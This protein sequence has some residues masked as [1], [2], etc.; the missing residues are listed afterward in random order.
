MFNFSAYLRRRA[1]DTAGELLDMTPF[2]WF[3]V[4]VFLVAT[5]Q[6][7]VF[8]E[9]SAG[10]DGTVTEGNAMEV[11]SWLLLL[12]GLTLFY[13]LHWTLC[14]LTPAHPLLTG[15]DDAEAPQREGSRPARKWIEADAPYETRPMKKGQSRME[16]LFPFG[17]KGPSFYIFAAR[18][19]LFSTAILFCLCVQW[20]P[21]SGSGQDMVKRVLLSALPL[22]LIIV[23]APAKLL[24]LVVMVTSVEQLKNKHDIADTMVEMK[25]ESALQT[26]RVLSVVMSQAVRAKKIGERLQEEEEQKG[27]ACFPAKEDTASVSTTSRRVKERKKLVLNQQHLSELRTTFALFD[28]DGSGD[29]DATEFA[30]M[31]STLGVRLPPRVVD[32]M[33]DEI[34]QT[35]DGRVEFEEFVE[36]MVTHGFTARAESD[37]PAEIVNYVFEM[38]DEDRSGTISAVELRQMMCN[39][40]ANNSEHELDVCMQMFDLDGSGTITKAEF[41]KAIEMMHTFASSK[42]ESRRKVV[43]NT[44]G[45]LVVVNAEIEEEQHMVSTKGPAAAQPAAAVAAAAEPAAEPT[46]E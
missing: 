46:S 37:G 4:G 39:F 31:M 16:A 43:C 1:A 29:I 40:G 26:L 24:P 41:L 17:S 12:L 36:Y 30:L 11:M 34:D 15:L 14:Q 44:K 25:A 10:H 22:L 18:T 6:I 20:I 35:K 2:T 33:F 38:L 19:L 23:I 3:V 7:L 45:Q 8:L 13:R 32:I 28:K 42:N 5:I 21:L 27:F 9:Y